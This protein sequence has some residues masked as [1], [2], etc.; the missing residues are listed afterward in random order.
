MAPWP[1][2]S[3]LFSAAVPPP[4]QKQVLLVVPKLNG[5][6]MS[7]SL[8]FWR[9]PDGRDFVALDAFAQLAAIDITR[10]G[11]GSV[12]LATPIGDAPIPADALRTD[13]DV[14]FVDTVILSKA[15]A[16]E[17]AFE[18]SEFA[19]KINLPWKPGATADL[20]A[21]TASDEPVDIHAPRASLSRWR[22]ELLTTHSDGEVFASANHRFAGALGPGYWRAD[23]SHGVVGASRDLDFQALSWV[24]DRG[25]SRF[26]VGQERIGLHPLLASF[27]LSGVQ[28]SYSNRPDIAYASS[29]SGD[30]QLVPYQARP[31]S[32]IRGNGPPGG[33]AEL[34]FGGQVLAR[35]T[36]RLDGRYEFRDVPASPGDAIPIEVAVYAFGETGTP[37]RVDET[38]SQA[39]NLQLPKGT[40][41]H[42][43]GAGVNGFVLDANRQG[44]G[45]AAFYQFRGGL[46]NRITAEGVVQS[47]DGHVQSSV[48]TAM[49]LGPVGTWAVYAGQ[50]DRGA[51]ARQI[52]GDGRR[53]EWYWRANWLSYDAGYQNENAEETENRRVEVGRNFGS[54]LRVSLIHADARGQFERDIRYTK[55]AASWRPIRQL[56]LSARPEYDGRYAFDAQWYVRRGT[57]LSASRY[58]DLGQ[59]ALDQDISSNSRLNVSAQHDSRLGNRLNATFNQYRGG[60]A[61]LAWAAGILRSKGGTG[62]LGEVSLEIRPGLSARAQ[63][64]RDPLREGDGTVVG[65]SLVAD[66]AVTGAGLARGTLSATQA[67]EGGIS[68]VVEKPEGVRSDLDLAGIPI[69]VDGHVRIRTE[70]GGHFHVA[71]LAPGVYRVELDNEGLPIELAVHQPPRRVEVRAGSLTRVDFG[72]ELRLGLAGKV[73]DT[74]GKPLAD[75]TIEVVDAEGQSRGKAQS[76]QF[77]YFRVDGL[78][79]GRYKVRAV[80]ASGAI[81]AEG[82]AV[83]DDRF[84]FGVELKA[85]AGSE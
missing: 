84:V 39:G 83:L 71:D 61:H 70:P 42:F 12:T 73:T 27:D 76:S 44:H 65:V 15:L 82:E 46:S 75:H 51:G 62:Y 10:E 32:V 30:G 18:E 9:E 43:A 33:T 78:P 38:Y 23:L 11:D 6:E 20:P 36:I 26:L 40:T 28:Y 52:L 37:L 22:S 67:R 45:N 24:V 16:A 54:T 58:G 53:G 57:R 13:K 49:N 60:P 59:L 85:A 21:R 47:L 31:T 63:V 77:G 14:L 69:L 35:Q 79:P 68:G 1:A 4:S 5:R 25:P 19:L 48:G 2:P 55:P 17:V 64:L 34:R 56:Q 50:N 29:V 3:I 81:L 41:V 7:N 72:L 8:A 80:D 74:S 66:F